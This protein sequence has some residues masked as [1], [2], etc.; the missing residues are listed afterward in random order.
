MKRED[1]TMGLAEFGVR[2]TWAHEFEKGARPR[3]M[4]YAGF[5]GLQD[6]ARVSYLLNKSVGNFW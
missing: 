1:V 5:S 6:L 3:Q 2:L 4:L